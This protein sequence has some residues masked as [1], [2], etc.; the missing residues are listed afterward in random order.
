LASRFIHAACSCCSPA[1]TLARHGRRFGTLGAPLPRDAGVPRAI[2]QPRRKKNRL[3]EDVVAWR[4]IEGTKRGSVSGRAFG[5]ETASPDVVRIADA[6]GEFGDLY[7]G[8][9]PQRV[10][11]TPVVGGGRQERGVGV[12]RTGRRRSKL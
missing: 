8:I 1:N 9:R 5:Y 11:Y 7:N 2:G 6:V 10:V 3:K 4:A 12:R